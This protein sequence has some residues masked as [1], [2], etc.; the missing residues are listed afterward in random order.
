[1][2]TESRSNYRLTILGCGSSPG[3]PRVGGDWG[4]CDPN[5]PKNLRQRCSA[6]FERFAN[7]EVTR[8]LVD[9]GP[10]F[11]HQMLQANVDWV[12]GVVYTHPHADHLHGIDDLR[13]FVINRRE[14]V[15]VYANELTAERMHEA[16]GYCFK[17]PPG[18]S[19]PPILNDHRIDHAQPVIVEGPA[20]HV[21][22]LPYQQVHGD[23][24]SLGFR[25]GNI[26]YSSDVSDLEPES[27]ELLS[28]LD[29]WIVDA[30][31]YTPH[32]SHF[33]V[34]EVLSWVERLEPKRTILT[35]MHIDLDYEA[36]LK[37]LPDHVEPAYDGMTINFDI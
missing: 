10:D 36:L 12:D 6:L 21:E 2:P 25:C 14:R 26:A 1:M 3:T 32:P 18:S 20:G 22:L 23:I 8:V 5:N 29:V 15:D 34:D 30:L 13:A 37:Y 9:T 27:I 28:D 17:T 19:Y 31:R 4:Q 33:S 35:H 7:D 11:R 24:H 16:F